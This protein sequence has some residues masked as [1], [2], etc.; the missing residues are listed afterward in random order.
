MYNVHFAQ[1]ICIMYIYYNGSQKI[2]ERGE[3]SVSSTSYSP[4]IHALTKK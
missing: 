3:E 4:V 2:G 1:Y